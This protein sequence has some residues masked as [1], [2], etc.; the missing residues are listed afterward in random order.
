[1]KTRK[2]TEQHISFFQILPFII[3][4]VGCALFFGFHL[5]RY[6]SFSNLKLHRQALADWADKNYGLT[7]LSFIGMYILGM[8]CSMPISGF[9]AILSG[10]L[11]GFWPGMLYSVLSATTGS[12]LFFIL[13]RGA[14]GDWLKK[15]ASKRIQSFEVGFQKNAFNYIVSLRLIP[16][17]P[18]GLINI[19]AAVLHVELDIFISATFI[20]IIPAAGIYATL[21]QHLSTI[22]QSSQIPDMKIMLEPHIVLPLLG[23]ALLGLLPAI[24]QYQKKAA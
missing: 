19:A 14:F 1:M 20:G 24:Y 16:V 23:L 2:L 18:F 5:Y 15:I 22:V 7:V 21:G 17:V 6:F 13:A 12:T 9:F 8:A 11:F 3:I 4:L 10:F